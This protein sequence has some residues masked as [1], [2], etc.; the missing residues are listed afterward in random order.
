MKQVIVGAYEMGWEMVQLSLREG[1]G[2]EFYLLP[3]D[4]NYARI[5]VGADNDWVSV[6]ETLFHEVT[7]LAA[8]RIRCRFEHS[9]EMAR[10]QHAYL[11]VMNH[12][13]FAEM[14][15]LTADYVSRCWDDLKN[16]HKGW[17]APPDEV[18]TV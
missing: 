3:G 11:F 4:I 5:K 8:T 13:Q 7:E 17:S 6:V 2:G 12:P 9:N 16:A 10:D 14:Q 15:A 1:R 18:T